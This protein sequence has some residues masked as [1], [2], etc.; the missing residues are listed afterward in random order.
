MFRCKNCNKKNKQIQTTVVID[1]VPM[2]EIGSRFPIV[3]LLKVRTLP[4]AVSRVGA[5][6]GVVCHKDILPIG[7]LDRCCNP[8]WASSVL[9]F[10]CNRAC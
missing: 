7:V 5:A 8:A 6:P 3:P 4:A 1:V 9:A 10:Y 2:F